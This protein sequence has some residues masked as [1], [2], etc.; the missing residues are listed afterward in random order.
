MACKWDLYMSFSFV[1]SLYC[2][3]TTHQPLGPKRPS[4]ET[5]EA[6]IIIAKFLS[7]SLSLSLSAGT[8]SRE[9]CLHH[10]KATIWSSTSIFMVFITIDS[11]V[12][13]PY[14]LNLQTSSI[15]ASPANI[16][17]RIPFPVVVPLSPDG[18]SLPT[19][20]SAFSL[21]SFLFLYFLGFWLMQLSCM[22][23]ML[24][25]ATQFLLLDPLSLYGCIVYFYFLYI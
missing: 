15:S 3:I 20:P 8:F 5:I 9:T 17:P 19:I 7:S 11:S 13:F 6:S 22:R 14:Q 16:T 12:A 1:I 21:T 4:Y 10:L 24:W 25:A 23:I 18:S 2:C